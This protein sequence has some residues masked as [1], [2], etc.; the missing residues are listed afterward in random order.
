MTDAEAVLGRLPGFPQIC[1]PGRNRDLDV[2]AARRALQLLE[3]NRPVE[4]IAEGFRSV[5]HETMAAAIRSLAASRGAD[6]STHAL[7]AFGGAGPGH[8]C[9]VARHLG[10]DEVWIPRTAG[11]FSAVGIGIARRRVEAV[12]PIANGGLFDARMKIEERKP[13]KG[14]RTLNLAARYR[15]TSECISL[16]LEK[17]EVRW[18]PHIRERFDAAHIHRFGFSRPEAQVEL[19]ELRLVIEEESSDRVLSMAPISVP[20]RTVSAYFGEWTDV[21]LCGFDDADGLEGPALVQGHGCTVVIEPG[22][23]ATMHESGLRLSDHGGATCALGR[24]FD[25]I[26]TAVLGARLMGVAEQMGE[27]LARLARSV[28]IRE[29]RDFS[30]AIF[31]GSGQLV[32][33]APHIPVHLGAM[34]ETVRSLM[35]EKGERFRPGQHWC[36]NDPY[37]GGSHLPDITVISPIFWPDEAMPALFVASRGHHIDVGGSRPGSMPAF[38]THIDEEG[39]RIRHHLLAMDGRFVTPDLPGCREPEEVRADLEAQVA[40]ANFGIRHLKDLFTELG[41]PVL[42]AQ[43]GHLMVQAETAVKAVLVK[44]NGTYKGREVL[45]DGTVISVLI[46]ILGAE[47]EVQIRAPPSAGNLNAPKAVARAVLLYV[48]RCLVDDPLPLN[49]GA[50]RPFTIDIEPGGLFSPTPPA[51][52]AGGNVESS[53]RLVDAMLS[54]LGVQAA[55]QGTMNNLT[56]GRNFSMGDQSTAGDVRF[57]ETRSY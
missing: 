19:V 42:R 14:R 35:S 38:S 10:I 48:F 2:E 22:W 17:E 21:P 55:S 6:P 27:Q 15:G 43:M 31:D 13:F 40:A 9:G 3:P 50:L 16:P 34:G 25:P 32:C 49:E 52:V 36:C 12:V 23:S 45:D 47:A 26:H 33:N 54:A 8:A 57:L 41:G 5:A 28:S 4:E 53:Q 37:A 51:A 18:S 46:S 1:G 30:C 29:R 56:I 24:D 11:V 7:I 39:I 44:M 20:I